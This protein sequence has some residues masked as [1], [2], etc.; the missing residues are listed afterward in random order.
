M[1]LLT[2]YSD[3]F[4]YTFHRQLIH[5]LVSFES[6]LVSLSESTNIRNIG[7]VL[8]IC[9]TRAVLLASLTERCNPSFLL[10]TRLGCQ[11]YITT[12]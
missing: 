9:L 4:S 1:I 8:S 3:T 12:Q 2:N 6:R 10:S 5:I 7:L 11:T